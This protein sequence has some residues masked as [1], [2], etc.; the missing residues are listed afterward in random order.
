MKNLLKMNLI[1]HFEYNIKFIQEEL[2]NDTKHMYP[3][4][5]DFSYQIKLFQLLNVNF[6]HVKL[7]MFLQ[8]IIK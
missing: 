7:V 6:Q 1:F 5:K 8:K 2:L 4:R 3:E